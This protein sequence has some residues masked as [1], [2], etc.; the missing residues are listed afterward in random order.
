MKDEGDNS[1][2]RKKDELPKAYKS[3]DDYAFPNDE[4]C[5]PRCKNAAYSV[6]FTS[7]NDEC[8]FL[9]WKCVLRKCTTCT[10]IA[11]P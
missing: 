7:T 2:G 4:T 5:H 8:Q 6:L 11:L 10:S 1:C 3:Y 9:N